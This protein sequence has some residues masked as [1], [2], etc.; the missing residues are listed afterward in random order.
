M[1]LVNGHDSHHWGLSCAV[2][3][4]SGP[5]AALCLLLLAQDQWKM[6]MRVI[7]VDL[8]PHGRFRRDCFCVFGQLRLSIMDFS[9]LTANWCRIF[10]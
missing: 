7:T 8:R 6:C 2:F 5:S 10:T 4:H 1:E 9:V 3:G